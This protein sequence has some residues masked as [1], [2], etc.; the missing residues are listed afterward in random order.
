VE[1][2]C[3]Y[4]SVP[5]KIHFVPLKAAHAVRKSNKR[6]SRLW[7]EIYCMTLCLRSCVKLGCLEMIAYLEMPETWILSSVVTNVP[8]FILCPVKFTETHCSMLWHQHKFVSN[9]FSLSVPT[10]L[11]D[12]MTV[13][14]HAWSILHTVTCK[15]SLLVHYRVSLLLFSQAH[16][17]FDI[18]SL[19]LPAIRNNTCYA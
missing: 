6:S 4:C 18:G 7:S 13:N 19:P 9:T 10:F 14:L 8:V 5:Y 17:L 15:Y 11:F 1:F 16:Q 3:I 12:H 2:Y